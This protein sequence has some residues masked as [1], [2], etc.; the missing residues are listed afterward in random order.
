[1][2]LDDQ[3]RACQKCPLYLDMPLAPVPGFGN[4]NAKIMLVGEAPGKDEA[5]VEEP[6]VGRCG[7]FMDMHLIGPAGLSR[8]DLY[9][10]NVIR[11]MCRT[12]NKNR[13]PKASEIKTCKDW[14]YQEIIEVNP[15]VIITLGDTS[16]KLLC[17]NKTYSMDNHVGCE[18]TVH[19]SI[20]GIRTIFP[21]F[22]PSYLMTYSRDKTERALQVFKRAKEI[23]EC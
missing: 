22:H 16:S 6:F 3:I 14:L 20:I 18:F 21:C 12:G 9:I 4:K 15:K 5:I 8:S 7:K 19:N 10:A 1:M 2:N 17:L 23:A 11:C 13:K